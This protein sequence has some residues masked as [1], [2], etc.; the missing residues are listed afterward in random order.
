MYIKVAKV[1]PQ[2]ASVSDIYICKPQ[3][4][5]ILITSFLLPDS[6][7]WT[8]PLSLN[9]QLLETHR[10]VPNQHVHS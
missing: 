4:T 3:R 6:T 9:A 7:A 5:L 2:E 8:L 10:K 1:S